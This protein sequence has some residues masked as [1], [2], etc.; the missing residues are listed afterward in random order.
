MATHA[1]RQTDQTGKSFEY[2]CEH[3]LDVAGYDVNEQVSIGLRPTGGTHYTD[4]I[5]DDG[6]ILSLKYQD[7]AGTA[8]EKIPYEQICLQH[9]VEQYN[10]KK[11][12]IVLAGPGW[13]H[14]DCYRD[15]CLSQW[16]NT[17]DVIILNFDEF[18]TEFN[19]HTILSQ[20]PVDSSND[21]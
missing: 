11:G 15:N 6:I 12:I 13:K 14:D 16:L 4:L 7:V 10:Y 18:L 9:A 5:V 21:D 20:L 1:S 2:L 19:L 17:P 3:L 8:E